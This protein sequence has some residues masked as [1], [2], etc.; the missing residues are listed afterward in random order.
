MF[1]GNEH[2][3]NVQREFVTLVRV[4]RRKA[5]SCQAPFFQRRV[6]MEINLIEWKFIR[7]SERLVLT[8][9]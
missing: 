8:I 5:I 4:G 9:N 6:N 2:I 1:Q 3:R 7:G